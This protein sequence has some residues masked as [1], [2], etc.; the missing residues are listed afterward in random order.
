VTTSGPALAES[1]REAGLDAEW[2]RPPRAGEL[3]AG[4]VVMEL[5]ATASGPMYGDLR[6]ELKRTLQ[7]RRSALDRYLIELVERDTWIQGM[8]YVLA[9]YTMEG[10]PW[11]TYRDEDHVWV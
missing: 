3:A 10:R 5:H 7:M 1:L 4:E 11:P 6:I 8:K 2:V 9:D